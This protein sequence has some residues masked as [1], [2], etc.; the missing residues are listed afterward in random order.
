MSLIFEALKGGG[1]GRTSTASSPELRLTPEAVASPQPMAAPQPQAVVAPAANQ[2]ATP[3]GGLA[4]AATVGM[5][6]A[7]G[8]AWLYQS[9]RDAQPSRP[10]PQVASNP[11]AIAVPAPVTALAP[12]PIAPAPVA[13]VAPAP[14]PAVIAAVAP[15]VQVAAVVPAV[16]AVPSPAPAPQPAPVAAPAVVISP[17]APVAK[18]P[19][20]ARQ[21]VAAAPA[22]PVVVAKAPAPAAIA[23]APATKASSPASAAAAEPEPKPAPRPPINTQVQLT[24]EAQPFDVRDAFQGFI[25]LMQ[26][27]Q[28]PEAQASADQITKALGAKHV[29]SLRA[30]GYLALKKN[31]LDQAKTQYLQLQQILPEDREAGLNLALIDW[32]MGDREAA[33]KRVARLM[34]KYPNDPEIRSLHQNVRNQ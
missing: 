26:L 9:G 23:S 20:V 30:Q 4:L 19:P 21:V 11:P 16:T 8:G 14:A 7:G 18:K 31:E 12:A 28:L 22:A 24:S 29:V 1:T 5:V 15:P 10:S 27:G 6:I 33:A 2:A 34:D 13:A 3:W 17:T 32:R 25:R